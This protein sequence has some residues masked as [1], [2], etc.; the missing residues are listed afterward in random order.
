MVT[1]GYI[2]PRYWYATLWE[3]GFG[4][5]GRFYV[6]YIIKAEL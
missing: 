4:W 5:L 3:V 1:T 2:L 6:D